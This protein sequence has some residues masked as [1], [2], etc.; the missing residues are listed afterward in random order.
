ML[1]FFK[2]KNDYTKEKDLDDNPSLITM[3][4]IMFIHE[5]MTKCICDIKCLIEGHGTGFFCKIPF[6]DFFHL[7]PVLITNNH[8][9]NE[10]DIVEG[11]K[12]NI[13]LNKKSINKEIFIDNSRKTYTNE[14]YDITIIEIK[15][16]DDLKE[17]QFLEIDPK[18]NEEDFVKEF[19]KKD[20]Y[21]IGNIYFY[22]TGKIW[23]IS[24]DKYEIQHKC[25]TQPGM[26]GS[27]IICLANY[28]V[29][30]VHKGSASKN[31]NLGTFIRE[32]IKEFN[33][34]F[35]N[36]KTEYLQNVNTYNSIINISDK[37]EERQEE[38][39]KEKQEEKQNKPIKAN[40]NQIEV[41]NEYKNINLNF[42]DKNNLP[43]YPKND[44]NKYENF[45]ISYINPMINIDTESNNII[46]K[47]LKDCRILSYSEGYLFELFV[48]N[49]NN[50][51]YCD[52]IFDVGER[53]F[54]IIQMDDGCLILGLQNYLEIIEIK[55]DKINILEKK[56]LSS[57]KKIYKFSN[58]LIVEFENEIV[59]YSYDKRGIIKDK[60]IKIK[61]DYIYDICEINEN[62]I[63][64][65]YENQS[66]FKKLLFN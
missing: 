57:F 43:I 52:I 48:Y 60:N 40:E 22:T 19:K 42:T 56:L 65:I 45:D 24:I 21:I 64:I 36:S 51:N 31:F 15:S 61:S 7:L 35:S 62:L 49:I 23:N 30:G 20:V 10:K 33:K 37:K 9:L 32:P 8:V 50:Y 41:E 18:I 28:K 17:E 46:V 39:L 59:Y 3:D 54:K 16:N 26:S 53:I 63:A 5:Q 58:N 25:S 27:P 38:N 47:I 55:E 29:I 44:N 11:K 34:K 13:S 14:F 6:P 1:N 2:K 66:L 4:Q 12:I